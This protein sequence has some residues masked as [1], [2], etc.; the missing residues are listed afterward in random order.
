MIDVHHHIL[1]PTAPNRM[2]QYMAGWSPQLAVAEMDAVGIATA[3]G[4]PGPIREGSDSERAKKAREWNLYGA[5][6]NQSFPG[7]FGL[8]ASLPF[9]AVLETLA[10]IDFALDHLL[11]DGFGIST[12]YGERWLGDELFQPIWSKLDQRRAVVFVHPHDAACCAPEEMS[13]NQPGMD[14]SW[15]EWPMNT[16]RAIMSLMISG[17]LRRFPNIRF[18]FAHG[19]GVM[20]LLVKRVGGLAAWAAVGEEG[21]RRYF[22]QGVESDFR[23]LHFECAQ[24]CSRT[25]MDAL[26]SLVPDTQILFGSDYSFFPLN[27][28]TKQFHDLELPHATE[29]AIARTN[30]TKLLPRWA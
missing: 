7:R 14:G 19:G 18:I 17:T 24:A 26:R 6:L 15:I 13:Y 1:P 23:N 30:A 29:L 28:A 2:Q 5:S 10:E 16:A 27:Y 12:S 20:P 8:F 21:L 22:P 9:P 11:A 25:N 4:Y 3:I